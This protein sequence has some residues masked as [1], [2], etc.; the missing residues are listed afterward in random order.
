MLEQQAKARGFP[1]EKTFISKDASDE[2]YEN[3]LL[4]ALKR[5][6]DTG[7]SS[8]V[9]GD[10]FLEDIR[11]YRERMLVTVGVNSVF[12]L[13]KKDTHALARRFIKLGFKAVVTWLIP[14]F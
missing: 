9:F 10:I 12:P 8:V 1:L 14:R 4:K 6:R 7:A 11:K 13:W 2:E 5:Q 3:E